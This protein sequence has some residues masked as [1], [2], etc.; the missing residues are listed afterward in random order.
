[1]E[2][3][4]AADLVKAFCVHELDLLCLSELGELGVGLDAVLRHEGGVEAWIAGLLQSSVAQPVAV[5]ADGH[6][7]TIV[8]SARVQIDQ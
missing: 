1:M 7:A 4:L 8:R 2:H 5:Y 3:S 6:Y